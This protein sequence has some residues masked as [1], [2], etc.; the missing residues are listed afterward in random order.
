MRQ[1]LRSSLAGRAAHGVQ[2][3]MAALEHVIHI[4][5]NCL[6]RYLCLKSCAGCLHQAMFVF[7]WAQL[8]SEPFL[9]GRANSY[10]TWQQHC[11]RLVRWPL[12]YQRVEIFMN[13]GGKDRESGFCSLWIHAVG[14]VEVATT[15]H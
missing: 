4:F 5:A 14:A 15:R 13:E 6:A 2:L 10:E 3:W 8:A 12:A 1:R 9:P 11:S 7:L